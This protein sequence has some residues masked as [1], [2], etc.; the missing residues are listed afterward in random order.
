MGGKPVIK[1]TRLTV[2]MVLR[3]LGGGMTAAEIR[4]IATAISALGH[5]QACAVFGWGLYRDP[6]RQR[7]YFFGTGIYAGSGMQSAMQDLW[8]A[9]AGLRPAPC[10][11]R[12]DLP[13]P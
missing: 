9:A 4:K 6:G 13:A 10:N 8:N 12:G 3:E 1:G 2:E 5:D 7:D 11:V